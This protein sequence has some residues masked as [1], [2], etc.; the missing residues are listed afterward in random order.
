M[1]K[2]I[3][4][5]VVAVLVGAAGLGAWRLFWPGSNA[6]WNIVSTQCV[7]QAQ[8]QAAQNVCVKVDLPGGYALLKDIRGVA[9]YLLIPTT[10]IGGIESSA[11]LDEGAPNYWRDAWQARGLVEQALHRP[12][13]RD[14]IGLAINSY[15][16]RTQNQLHIHID[17]M[18]PD[19]VAALAA[20]RGKLGEQ[21]TE[22]PETLAGQHYRA[23]LIPGGDLGAV[24]PFKLLYQDIHPRGGVMASQTLL[25]T[26]T[27]MPDGQ[28]GFILL[29]DH[30]R[31][32]STASAE[33]LLDHDC[34]MGK[35]NK[36]VAAP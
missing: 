1:K 2:A 36:S 10:R 32:G 17:C 23:R 18:R 28:P 3:V 30:V 12:L 21:W 25:L 14:E 7:P 27:T 9:Q 16:G 33:G 6:L 8:A 31:V 22:L 13:A 15:S 11:L 20:Q 24:D 4:V 5:A 19:V 26:G 29:N 35:Q 34:G